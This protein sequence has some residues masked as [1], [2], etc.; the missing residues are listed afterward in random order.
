MP[1]LVTP[2]EMMI[3]AISKPFP[4]K[5]LFSFVPLSS[6]AG[7]NPAE[8]VAAQCARSCSVYIIPNNFKNGNSRKWHFFVINDTFSRMVFPKSATRQKS[9]IFRQEFQL[10]DV[11]RFETAPPGVILTD[12]TEI[13]NRNSGKDENGQ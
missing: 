8:G 5:V 7:R 9:E 12:G 10:F 4:R 11:F 3:S 1:V 13:R 2:L 6:R